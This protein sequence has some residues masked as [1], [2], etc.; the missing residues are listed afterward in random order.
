MFTCIN[1]YTTYCTI[2]FI[3]TNNNIPSIPIETS[4]HDGKSS[5]SETTNIVA[6]TNTTTISIESPSED[7]Q[8]SDL[9]T[10]AV[11][12]NNTTVYVHTDAPSGVGK[13]SYPNYK[14][15]F[16]FVLLFIHI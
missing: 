6:V 4:T 5:L 7:G 9:T 16:C 8:L 1:T 10:I 15:I 11:I 13:M 12:T 14:T 3:I 2:I